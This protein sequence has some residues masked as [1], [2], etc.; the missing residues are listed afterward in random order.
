MHG[1]G[2]GLFARVFLSDWRV[3]SPYC[4]P[5]AGVGMATDT[6]GVWHP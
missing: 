4:A 1:L 5:F 2:E 6:W 3:G